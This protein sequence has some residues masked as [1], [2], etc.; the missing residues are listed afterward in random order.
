MKQAFATLVALAA[1]AVALGAGAGTAVTVETI[2]G[3]LRGDIVSLSAEGLALTDARGAE[4][5]VEL[6][7]VISVDFGGAERNVAPS[8][9]AW[10][11]GGDV[12][13]GAITVAGEESAT[14]ASAAFGEVRVPIGELA[15]LLLGGATPK[16]C[17][18]LPR[19]FLSAKLLKDRVHLPSGDRMDG[20]VAGLSAGALTFDGM[21]GELDYSLGKLSGV[22]FGA[23]SRRPAAPAPLHAVVVAATG[24]RLSGVPAVLAGGGLGLRTPWGA[25][26]SIQFGDVLVVRIRGGRAVP[27][28]ELKP[29]RIDARS[30]YEGE[31]RVRAPLSRGTDGRLVIRPHAT[32][33]YELGGG[34][35]R[36]TATV[37]VARPDGLVSLRMLADGREVLGLARLS[38][39]DGPKPISV[40][41][42]GAKRLAVTCGFGPDLDDAGDALVLERARLLRPKKAKGKE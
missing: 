24:E 37:R 10:L 4:R 5:K 3:K 42:A 6:D 35:S 39:R 8:P 23:A 27:L 22:L 20:L 31:P 1:H 7:S 26:C 41:L 33:V 11:V 15:G 18:E 34:Y 13:R 14:F 9:G 38:G 28:A 16:Q 36:L 21:L 29:L 19:E 40:E 17:A 2:S 30:L 25:T 12:I 32:L